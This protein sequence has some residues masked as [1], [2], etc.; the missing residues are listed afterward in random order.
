MMI[1]N[2]MIMEILNTNQF[3]SMDI[4]TTYVKVV[5]LNE[6]TF[7]QIKELFENEGPNGA[8]V[9]LFKHVNKIYGTEFDESNLDRTWMVDNIGVKWF[10]IE[11]GHVDYSP[12]VEFVI[13]SGHN[14]PTEYL[15]NLINHLT[16]WDK[17]IAMYGLY[18][19]EVYKL[20]GAYVYGYDWDDVEDY[21]DY[22]SARMWD[23][24]D[25]RDEIMD[26][27]H[28]HRDSMYESYL[29]AKKEREEDNN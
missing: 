1:V 8:Y 14:V 12:E 20:I 2:I 16:Q 9:D 18:E 24:D 13:E 27:L 26:E 19:E 25:Y 28:D 10:S 7:K 29:E 21:D 17:D 5:N 22:D 3:N 23:D 11:F 4:M 6:E 15:Q